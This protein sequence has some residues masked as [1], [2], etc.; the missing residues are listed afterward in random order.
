MDFLTA[1]SLPHRAFVPS[2]ERARLYP[3]FKEDENF[4]AR[5]FLALVL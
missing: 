4:E 3:N 2:T 1:K 5:D